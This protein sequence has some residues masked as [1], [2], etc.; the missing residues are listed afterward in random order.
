MAGDTTLRQGRP[1]ATIPPRGPATRPTTSH[2]SVEGACDTA[3]AGPAIRHLARHDTAQCASSLG[4]LYAQ[5]GSV[6]CAPCALDPVLTQCTV[7]SHC[8]R[9]CS[10]TLFTRFSKKK[11]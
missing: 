5:P 7:F 3:G 6:G 11:K 8:L 10:Q 1:Q 9:H 4:A 2:D